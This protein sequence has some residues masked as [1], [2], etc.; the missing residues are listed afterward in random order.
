MGTR[1][2]HTTGFRLQFVYLWPGE[3]NPL[4]SPLAYAHANCQLLCLLFEHIRLIELP[5]YILGL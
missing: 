4:N 1:K 5:M 2:D 3:T